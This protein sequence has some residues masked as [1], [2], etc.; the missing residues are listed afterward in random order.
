MYVYA[1]V[2]MCVLRRCSIWGND[3]KACR[4]VH[5]RL[6]SFLTSALDGD[7]W[8]ASSPGRLHARSLLYPVERGL[9]I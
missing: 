8:S 5:V 9:R 6:D 2:C 3:W 4:T 7:E 1:C